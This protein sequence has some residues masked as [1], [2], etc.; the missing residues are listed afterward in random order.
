MALR[1]PA[2]SPSAGACSAELHGP[3][4]CKSEDTVFGTGAGREG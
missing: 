1:R 2:S 3:G 4:A